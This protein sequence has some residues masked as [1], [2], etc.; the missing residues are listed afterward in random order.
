MIVLSFSYNY[1]KLELGL[2]I[3]VGF[4]DSNIVVDIVVVKI[5]TNKKLREEILPQDAEGNTLDFKLS[6]FCIVHFY[7]TP[8]ININK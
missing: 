4:E 5:T 6:V 3:A 2:L 8:Q 7:F 1:S